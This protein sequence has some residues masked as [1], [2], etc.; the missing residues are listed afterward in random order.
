VRRRQGLELE[1]E[2]REF[3]EAHSISGNKKVEE[4]VESLWWPDGSSHGRTFRILKDYVV[5]ELQGAA[6]YLVGRYP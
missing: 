3:L 4:S 6:T 2:A 1:P 5:G